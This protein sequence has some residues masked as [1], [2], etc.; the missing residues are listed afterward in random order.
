MA[1]VRPETGEVVAMYGGSD[2]LENQ[3]N[4]ATQMIGQA[5]ST[6]K[7][8]ALAAGL[9]NGVT[10]A[11]TFSGKNKTKVNDYVVV[12]YGDNSYGKRLLYLRQPK[13]R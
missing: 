4:N 8:F 5:G 7:P 3:F 9:E 2:Y 10:L 12:N 6:F 13:V 11:T 1:S